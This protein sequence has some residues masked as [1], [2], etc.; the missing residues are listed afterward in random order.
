MKTKQNKRQDYLQCFLQAITAIDNAV[1]C[2]QFIIKGYSGTNKQISGNRIFF[3]F[4]FSS[5]QNKIYGLQ[6]K[7]SLEENLYIPPLAS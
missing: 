5:S 2:G 7:N 1:A 6:E 3:M 4:Q